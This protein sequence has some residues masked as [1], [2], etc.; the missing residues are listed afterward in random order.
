MNLFHRRSARNN[1]R[2]TATVEFA[3][4]APVFLMLILGMLEASRMFETYGQLAQ[5]ARDGGRLG[6]MDRADWVAS[7]IRTNDK[8]ISDIRNS[9][10]ASGYDPDELEISIEPAGRPGEG[11]NL[12]DPINDL[13]LFQVRIALPMS[14]IAAMPVPDNLDYDLSTAVIF[15]NTKSTIVQ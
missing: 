13:E 9:L 6:A 8:I 3:V 4:I 5:V 1:R 14:Q 11:F 15:R 2:A 10:E 12:D 7:G